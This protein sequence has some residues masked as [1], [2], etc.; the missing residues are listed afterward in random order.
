MNQSLREKHEVFGLTAVGAHYP[1]D[2]LAVRVVDGV[3]TWV[4]AL[5]K[6]GNPTRKH[7]MKATCPDCGVVISA[8]RMHQHRKTATCLSNSNGKA[9]M[10]SSRFNAL[11]P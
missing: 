3:A 4:D 11:A 8:A 7:R 1:D 5:P 6:E 2:G 10:R 9:N